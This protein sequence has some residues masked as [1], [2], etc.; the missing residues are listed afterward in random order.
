MSETVTLSLTVN[1]QGHVLDVPAN[2][3]LV[4]LLR[5]RLQLRGTKAACD[6]G[7]CGACTVLV[8]GVP[9]TSCLTF[10]FVVDGRSIVTV[11]GVEVDGLLDRVQRAFHE[12]GVPQCG[13]CT[14]GM[15]MLGKALLDRE[16]QPDAAMVERWLNAN[17]CRCSGYQVFRRAFG[18]AGAGDPGASDP[19]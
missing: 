14:P 9:T 17:I 15:V 19:G 5:E 11:E 3:V 16:P 7:A 4:D 1:G 2:T 18:A 13:F 12:W 6:Q 10:A 8:D